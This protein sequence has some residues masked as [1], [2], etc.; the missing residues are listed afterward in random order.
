[1]KEHNAR[2]EIKAILFDA[3]NTIFRTRR[4]AK[5][6]D[7]AA[8]RRL[9]KILQQP[10]AE[11]Y[12]EWTTIVQRLR[13]SRDPKKRLRKYSYQR[14]AIKYGITDSAALAVAYQAFLREIL[15]IIELEPS[16]KRF[17]K[18]AS[19]LK[20]ALITEAPKDLTRLKLKKFGLERRFSIIITSD[21]IGKM[22][23]DAK[24]CTAAL[25]A[26]KKLG[27]TPAE[28]LAVGDS[29]HKDLQIPKT[30]GCRTALFGGTDKRANYN[31]KDYS[32]LLRILNKT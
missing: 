14:L 16:F 10:P 3:D 22:K 4:A 17:L 9:S 26:I 6:A 19:Y 18:H 11:L 29:F 23:P 28:C 21:D 25:R 7:M 24:Y 5:K 8:M 12:R 2:K 31:I 32:A 15:K 30:L 1:M 20:L 13:V 27:I